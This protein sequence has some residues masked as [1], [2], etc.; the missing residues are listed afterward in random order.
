M[1]NMVL[2]FQCQEAAGGK[3]VLNGVCGKKADVAKNS[4]LISLCNQGISSG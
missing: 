3:V 4:G 2:C 1:S